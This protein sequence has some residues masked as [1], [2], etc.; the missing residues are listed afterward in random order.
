MNR[1]EYAH[2]RK[3]NLKFTSYSDSISAQS[4]SLFGM[5]MRDARSKMKTSDMGGEGSK[6]IDFLNGML[7]E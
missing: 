5:T 3:W 4:L 2:F 6:N 7:F 1:V